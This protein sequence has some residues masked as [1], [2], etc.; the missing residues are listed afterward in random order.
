M[1][2]D[3]GRR[4]IG[5]AL[6]DPLGIIAQPY[7][8]LHPDSEQ[9]VI[10]RLKCIVEENDVGLVLVG[11]P[12]SMKGRATEKSTTIAAF[13]RRLTRALS[14]KIELWD[15]RFTSKY[16]RAMMKDLGFSARKGDIDKIAA[17]IMLAEYLKAR[18]ACTA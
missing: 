3:Y 13:V 10:K 2:V 15:E 1:A 7:R 5:I 17:C 16:A 9:E 12:I 6:S 4:R 14:V 8:V 11:N 18:S